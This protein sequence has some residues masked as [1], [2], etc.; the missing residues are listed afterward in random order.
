MVL[1]R[2]RGAQLQRANWPK[3]VKEL[4]ASER[5]AHFPL[6]REMTKSPRILTRR[7][8]YFVPVP[9]WPLLQRQRRCSAVPRR[10]RKTLVNQAPNQ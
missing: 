2:G 8:I 9:H 5:F 6:E 1:H 10:G 7:S 3:H 4:Y